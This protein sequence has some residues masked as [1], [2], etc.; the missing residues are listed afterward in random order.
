[1]RFHC[2]WSRR[3]I[4]KFSSLYLKWLEVLDV[5][6]RARNCRC[7]HRVRDLRVQEFLKELVLLSDLA[8]SFIVKSFIAVKEG[9]Q[10]KQLESRNN[11]LVFVIANHLSLSLST[12]LNSLQFISFL[13]LLA[14]L[15][16]LDI[17]CLHLFESKE[18]ISTSTLIKEES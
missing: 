18:Q 13:L 9:T 15:Y 17:I 6:L 4:T 7:Q 14:Y 1:M 8:G 5:I 16:M 12:E 11:S 2:L 3:L 10:S